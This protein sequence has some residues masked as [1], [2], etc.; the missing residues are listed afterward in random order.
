VD[1]ERLNLSVDY[2]NENIKKIYHKLF[3]EALR[4]YS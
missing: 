4:K 3:D 1:G 2:C